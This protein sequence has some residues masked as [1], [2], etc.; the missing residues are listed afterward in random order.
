M[1]GFVSGAIGTNDFS[2][3]AVGVSLPVGENGRVDLRYSQTRNGFGH[4]YGYGEPGYG[5]G[6]GDPVHGSGGEPIQA[7]IGPPFGR[8]I[9]FPGGGLRSGRSLSLGFRWEADK[10]R[11]DPAPPRRGR[12]VTRD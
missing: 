3:V 10:D 12:I 8:H 4:G 7:L 5:S 1:H 6:Y 2:S 9:L 11:A